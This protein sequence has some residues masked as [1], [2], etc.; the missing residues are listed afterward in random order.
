MK[1]TA[2]VKHEAPDT[3][4]TVYG[5]YNGNQFRA[6]V[7]NRGLSVELL[8]AEPLTIRQETEIIAAAVAL[9]K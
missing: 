6:H 3:G 1:I 2:T 8:S 9:A 5:H 4:T 7:E